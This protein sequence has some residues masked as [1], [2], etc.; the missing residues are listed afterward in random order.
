[1]NA[2]AL[3]RAAFPV[4]SRLANG[5]PMRV[6]MHG[7]R[8]V[9]PESNAL[10]LR[11]QKVRSNATSPRQARPLGTRSLALPSRSRSQGGARSL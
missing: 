3:P 6:R 2:N 4:P 7:P 11:A 8:E 9:S 1:M 5:H 10:V